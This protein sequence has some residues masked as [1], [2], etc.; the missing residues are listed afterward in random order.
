MEP[1]RSWETISL[2][3]LKQQ[4]IVAELKGCVVFMD[5]KTARPVDIRKLG[6]GWP[7]LYDGFMKTCE[8]SRKMREILESKPAMKTIYKSEAKL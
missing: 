6:G 7:E 3:S 5:V 2:F 4:A 1:T 8:E